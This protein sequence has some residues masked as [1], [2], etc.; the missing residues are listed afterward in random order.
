MTLG[1]FTMEPDR[2]SVQKLA[3]LMHGYGYLKAK[4]DVGQLFASVGG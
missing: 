2:A 3:D 4:V 1:T